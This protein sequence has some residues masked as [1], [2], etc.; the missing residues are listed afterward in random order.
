VHELTEDFTGF[1]GKWTRIEPAGH[2]EAPAVIKQDGRYFLL[3]S[4][5]TSW[6]PNDARYLVADSIW[7]PWR[8]AGN[9]CVG[10]NAAN[11]MGPDLTWGGQSTFILPR[12]DRPGE[13]VAMFDVWRPQNLV[14]SGYIWVPLEIRDGKMRIEWR[15]TWAA[16]AT[17][18][19]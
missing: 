6:D 7:G 9:P 2:N 12:P 13:Y 3:A 19:R 16:G 8:N 10:T 14:N 5:C 18:A 11:K 1:T 4:G 17:K 15:P